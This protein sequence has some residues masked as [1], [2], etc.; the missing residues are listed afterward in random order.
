MIGCKQA[1][2]HAAAVVY[3]LH[4]C[5]YSCMKHHGDLQVL[6]VLVP[7]ELPLLQ[8]VSNK[9]RRRAPA[10]SQ[11]HKCTSLQSSKAQD[12]FKEDSK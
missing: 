10:D 1:E 8:T 2:A 9:S 7:E 5:S 12:S 6:N 4:C 11:P 3:L